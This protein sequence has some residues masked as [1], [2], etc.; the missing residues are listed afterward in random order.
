MNELQFKATIAKCAVARSMV[1]FLVASFIAI[2]CASPSYA[3]NVVQIAAGYSHVLA[4][5]EDGAV[6]AWGSG[7]YGELGNSGTLTQSAP[8][9]VIGLPSIT[10]VAAAGSQQYALKADGTLYAWGSN[11]ITKVRK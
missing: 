5:R 10:K 1:L 6:A 11:W 2:T 8:V 9:Q 4:L 7:G 3:Q